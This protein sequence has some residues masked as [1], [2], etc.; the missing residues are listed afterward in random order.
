MASIY[1]LGTAT[2]TA[3]VNTYTP[4]TVTTGD[5]NTL[6][7]T[8]EDGTVTPITF[9]IGGTQTAAAASA[10]LIAAWNANTTTA[11]IAT[12]SGTT[13]VILTAVT[14]GIPF[15]VTSSVTGTGTLTRALTTPNKGASDWGTA[16][17]WSAGA[18]PVAS[19]SVTLD[20]RG[21]AA[22]L[23]GLN[24]S[25]ITLTN[26]NIDKGFTFAVGSTTAPLQISA[27]N[28]RIGQPASDGSSPSGTTLININFGSVQYT[29]RMLDSNSTGTSGLPTVNVKGSHASNKIYMSG[30]TLG[31]GTALPGDTATV[32][33]VSVTGGKLTV[34]SGVTWTT[35]DNNG[36]TVSWARGRLPARSRRTPARP[37][38][39]ARRSS[40]P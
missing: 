1:W 2:S 38:P 4:A 6:T 26:L 3:Q 28:W 18:V 8:A 33:A 5:V 23:Y 21:S 10:G 16:S 11:A 37:R 22:V 31:I 20:G 35:I 30:G 13:T 40:A 24:Q 39:R 12:A 36:G 32:S 14:A 34:G 15:A 7:Y 17:N 9:T 27:T 19:D 29:G 25:A